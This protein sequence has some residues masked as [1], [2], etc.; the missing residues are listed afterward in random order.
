MEEY[1][2]EEQPKFPRN[3][4]RFREYDGWKALT[5][6]LFLMAFFY[7]IGGISA[8]LHPKW[9]RPDSFIFLWRLFVLIIA[10]CLMWT[11]F[12]RKNIEGYIMGLFSIALG[13]IYILT[14]DLIPGAVDDT[15]IGVPAIILGMKSWYKTKIYN[16]RF[17]DA[18]ELIRKNDYKNGLKILLENNGFLFKKADE[19]NKNKK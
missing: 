17:K 10:Y 13:I 7:F 6:F 8:C 9:Y 11:A 16:E 12:D 2:I 19:E 18:M 5:I 4:F 15:I 14:P 3:L 1:R